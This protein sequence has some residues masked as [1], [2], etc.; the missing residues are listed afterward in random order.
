MPAAVQGVR[1]SACCTTAA[2]Y[3]WGSGAW[4]P[5][6]TAVELLRHVEWPPAL[7]FAA[8]QDSACERLAELALNDADVAGALLRQALAPC[9]SALA[10]IEPKLMQAAAVA[11]QRVSKL[12]R[13]NFASAAVEL[14]CS[15]MPVQC[16]R[17]ACLHGRLDFGPLPLYAFT[18]HPPTGSE[19]CT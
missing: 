2:S 8:L 5:D 17:T 6:S 15:S 7:V 11:F 18:H 13:W 3:A 10:A 1:F 14:G 12:G 4:W 16:C 19:G 9:S